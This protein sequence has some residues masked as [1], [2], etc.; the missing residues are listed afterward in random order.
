MREFTSKLIKNDSPRWLKLVKLQPFPQVL[1]QMDA[2][3]THLH[4]ISPLG[5][6]PTFF[7]ISPVQPHQF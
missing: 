4:S 1:A 7:V 3:S 6:W 2:P 5:L